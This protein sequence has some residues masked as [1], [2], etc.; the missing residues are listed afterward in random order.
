M[1]SPIKVSNTC[2]IREGVGKLVQWKSHLQKNK[3]L[4]SRK[5]KFVAST[6]S[7]NIMQVFLNIICSN[8]NLTNAMFTNIRFLFDM[9]VSE[10]RKSGQY[11]AK[12]VRINSPRVHLL[13]L[14]GG[15]HI[16]NFVCLQV[17]QNKN[18][19]TAICRA[20]YRNESYIYGLSSAYFVPGTCR[21]KSTVGWHWLK[22]SKAGCSCISVSFI[23]TAD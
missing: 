5:I 18:L 3:T 10:H 19:K 4:A 14:H 9:L 8:W 22:F 15:F 1:H 23:S 21:Q 12:A 11:V 16:K 13:G 7:V 2:Y 6:D 20:K 17:H